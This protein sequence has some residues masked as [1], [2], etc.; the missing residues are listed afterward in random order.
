MKTKLS[1]L[2]FFYFLFFSVLLVSAQ[3]DKSEFC[4]LFYNVENLFDVQDDSLSLDDEFTPQGERYWTYKRLNRKL[5]NTSKVI[6]NS[7]GWEIPTLIALC[8]I[9]NRYVLERLLE[10]TPLITYPY[11]IIHKESPDPRGI[12]VAL[13][14]DSERFYPL[15]YEYYPVCGK[16]GKGFISREIL[17]VSGLVGGK[18]TLHIFV[19]HWPSRYSGVMESRER[20][21]LA[22]MLLREELDKL[23]SQNK[24]AKVVILGDFNDQ[25]DDK[26]I[27][28]ILQVEHAWKEI[29]PNGL[30]NL[31]ALWAKDFGTLKYQGTWFVFDQIIVSGALLG[32]DRGLYT[33]KD[34]ASVCTFPFLLQH[35]KTYG[36]RKPFRTYN[37]YK[38]E[39]GFSDHLPITLRIRKH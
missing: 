26:S 28:N 36:G 15:N 14:Y 23:L 19:N 3:T 5:L 20:R 2:P 31:S 29:L 39:G 17:Y 10:D 12:D 16:G 37:G 1:Y 22:A 35:D 27:K 25:P 18:D 21:N 9:E 34:W 8:E 13:L 7:S 32:A 24:N 38:Y 11:K 30:Y 6:L 33:Q 4:I